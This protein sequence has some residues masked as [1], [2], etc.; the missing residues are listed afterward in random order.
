MKKKTLQATKNAYFALSVIIIGLLI[1]NTIACSSQELNAEGASKVIRQT[2]SLIE[3]DKVEVL[4]IAEET[5]ETR[6]V[7]FKVNDNQAVGK[8]R[9]YDQGWQLDELQNERGVWL[10]VLTIIKQIEEINVQKVK[11]QWSKVEGSYLRRVDLV[12][13]LLESVKGAADLEK[14][15]FTAVSEAR[16]KVEGLPIWTDNINPETFA[17]FQE[18]QEGLTSA[19]SHLLVVIEKYPN[20]KATENFKEVLSMLEATENRIAV[21][22]MRFNDVVKELN[23]ENSNSMVALFGKRISEIPYFKA[24]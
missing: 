21:E 16:V 3:L 22:K 10:P 1:S 8:M 18:A 14:L 5:N 4:G 2:L 19:L 20:L 9:R 12:P 13:A 11:D 24:R 23:L 15:T 6:L 7:K 17:K